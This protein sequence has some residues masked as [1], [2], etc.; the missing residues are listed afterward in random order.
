M[1]EKSLTEMSYDEFQALI[2]G[3][4]ERSSRETGEMPA[5]TFFEL[6]FE[7]LAARARRTIEVTGRIVDRELVL[8]LPGPESAPVQVQGNQIFVG[9]QRIVVRLEPEW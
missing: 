2:D 4:I 5:S 3:Y 1:V 9:D 6:L 8:S 7:R